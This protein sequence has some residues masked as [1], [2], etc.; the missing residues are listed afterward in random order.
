MKA[1]IRKNDEVHVI[2]GKDRGKRGRVVNVYP[3]TSKIMVEGIARASRHMRMR[4][5]RSSTRGVREG[6]I[7]SQELP[8][9][10]S[11]VQLVCKSCGKPTRIGHRIE[12]GVKARICRR[13]ESET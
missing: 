3:K 13:C 1:D 7:I 4:P 9:D 11:N 5:S 6:G 8:I 2:S 12:N 10:L